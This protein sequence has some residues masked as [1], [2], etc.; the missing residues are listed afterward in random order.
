MEP[1]GSVEAAFETPSRLD[2]VLKPVV[3]IETPRTI[4]RRLTADD[5]DDLCR[6]YADADVRRYFPEGTLDRS[7]TKQELDSIL[8]DGTGDGHELTLWA[9]IHKQTCRFIGRSGYVKWEIDGTQATE[10]AY[11][12]DKEFWGQGLG[13]EIAGALVQYGFAQL[14][15]RRLIALIDPRNTASIRTAEKAGF[16]YERD[17]LIGSAG[18]SIYARHGY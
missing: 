3:I 14:G 15:L 12:L 9:T 10:I 11:L 16:H 5:L 17:T 4:F 1:L 13:T 6:L 2:D 8:S 18:C 7:H